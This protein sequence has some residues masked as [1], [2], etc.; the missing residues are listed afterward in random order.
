MSTAATYRE[1][2]SQP[3]TPTRLLRKPVVLERLGF[4][5]TTLWRLERSGQ[6]PRSIRISANAVAW[7]EADIEEWIRQRVQER[8]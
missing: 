1:Q 7:R 6:F 8:A 3:A 4:S 2:Q 5:D